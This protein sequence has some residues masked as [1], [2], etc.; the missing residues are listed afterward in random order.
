MK[1]CNFEK[2]ILCVCL[3][4]NVEDKKTILR[5]ADNILLGRRDRRVLVGH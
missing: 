3:C 2:K 1:R 4:Y 5:E